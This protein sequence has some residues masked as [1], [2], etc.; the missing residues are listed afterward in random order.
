MKKYS[1]ITTVLILTFVLTSFISSEVGH[2]VKLRGQKQ[3]VLTEGKEGPTIV[4]LTGKGR[5]QN[6]FKM[7]YSKIK[8]TN[9]IFAYDR[10][11][12]GQSETLNNERTVDTMAYELN[13]LLMKEYIKPPFILVGHSL[14]GSIM[15]CFVHM[16]PEKVA[17]LVFVD[18]SSDVSYK[19]GLEV[20]T[21]NDKTKYKDEFKSF[22]NNPKSSNGQNAEGKYCFDFDS[23]LYATNHKIVKDLI[24]PSNIPIT[25]L[26]S[27]R[28]DKNNPYSYQDNSIYVSFVEGW[29]KSSPQI[30]II[31]TEKSGHFI[32]ADEPHLVL[33]EITE[34]SFK[35]IHK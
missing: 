3:F 8:K 30:K 11:G 12:I 5:T 28:A 19:K 9:Q 26:I 24:F 13:E 18:P 35:I 7:I 22:L 6:D 17:G 34:M 2:F 23:T 1:K 27:T 15:R 14:G 4:F 20:R 29:K 32:Q 25:V 31:T 10:A 33:N 16:Y 21:D